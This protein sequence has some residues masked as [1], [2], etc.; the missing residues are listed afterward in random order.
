MHNEERSKYKCSAPECNR[1]YFKLCNL[2]RHYAEDHSTVK[3]SVLQNWLKK[4]VTEQATLKK[5]AYQCH[6]CQ[7]IFSKNSNLTAHRRTHDENKAEKVKCDVEGCLKLFADERNLRKHMK[8]IHA[9]P[10]KKSTSKKAPKLKK[11]QMQSKRKNGL[12]MNVNETKLVRD[13]LSKKRKPEKSN[14]KQK[15]RSKEI[16]VGSNCV[17]SFELDKQM[18]V[19]FSSPSCTKSTNNVVHGWNFKKIRNNV[20]SSS[21]NL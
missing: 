16:A 15:A 11:N 6:I 8:R 19:E 5:T 3:I 12:T 17:E 20:Y 14:S 10:H 21:V 1:K 7:K 18:D 4:P 9:K 13:Q 2:K